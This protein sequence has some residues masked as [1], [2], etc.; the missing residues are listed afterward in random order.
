ML[1]YKISAV[2]MRRH[3]P[4]CM[5]Q[6][7]KRFGRRNICKHCVKRVSI[8]ACPM[9]MANHLYQPDYMISS[10]TKSLFPASKKTL[11]IF[12]YMAERILI[13]FSFHF[14]PFSFQF[15]HLFLYLLP[16]TCHL[17]PSWP[18]RD[19]IVTS[20]W[21]HRMITLTLPIYPQGITKESPRHLTYQI[22]KIRCVSA[23]R[24]LYTQVLTPIL[25]NKTKRWLFLLP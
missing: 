6:N 17:S 7:K 11:R 20:S 16:L 10:S 19:F 9:P 21:P 25:C 15:P 8:N 5:I 1:S 2:S 4:F 23:H 18:H 12:V 13:L 24:I 3:V 14:S 22:Q